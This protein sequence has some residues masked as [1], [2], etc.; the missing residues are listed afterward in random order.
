MISDSKPWL[1]VDL[2]E[3]LAAHLE[4]LIEFCNGE[5]GLDLC[6]DDFHSY[7]FWEI[8]GGT[9][10]DGVALVRRFY[11]TEEF[12]NLPTAPGAVDA[13][14]RL[15]RSY[16]LVVVTARPECAAFVTRRWLTRRLGDLIAEVTFTNAWPLPGEPTLGTKAGYC[17]ARGIGV[18]VE[19]SLD[20]VSEC[21]GAGMQA[22][23]L[24]KPWNRGT[25]PHGATRV[26]S[27]SEAVVVLEGLAAC[28]PAIAARR[29]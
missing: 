28:S 20:Y 12:A 26:S 11:E 24:D 13:M 18:I 19:D 3:V 21:C 5:R 6:L 7:R 9:P 2:D 27:W 4:G 17:R 16:R 23:L 14:R 8:W 1:A 10:A 22:V 29:C 15:S 25:T